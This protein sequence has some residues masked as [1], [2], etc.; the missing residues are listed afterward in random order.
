M[1]EIE[2]IPPGRTEQVMNAL[3][4]NEIVIGFIPG[5]EGQI[6]YKVDI[7]S[8]LTKAISG[9]DWFP[10]EPE[11]AGRRHEAFLFNTPDKARKIYSQG[12][13]GNELVAETLREGGRWGVAIPFE[14]YQEALECD[15]DSL[16]KSRELKMW[17]EPKSAD[18]LKGL[19]Q[20]GDL[21]KDEAKKGIR[22]LIK[23]AK[24]YWVFEAKEQR[25]HQVLQEA[26]YLE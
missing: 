15:K 13:I 25:K 17:L 8:I 1:S 2:G 24:W 20:G 18:E 11:M 21:R 10:V 7:K 9:P 26:P 14:N 16:Y 6:P 23:K 5:K 19:I 4:D 3:G 22:A 12:L